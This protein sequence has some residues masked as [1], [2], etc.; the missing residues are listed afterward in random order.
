MSRKKSAE[1]GDKIK[2]LLY[3][4]VRYSFRSESIISLLKSQ[5]R[6]ITVILVSPSQMIKQQLFTFK[7]RLSIIIE[8]N[9]VELN[10]KL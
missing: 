7:S 5:N 6:N 2:L 3:Q 4:L 1:N 10:Q 9:L 8:N